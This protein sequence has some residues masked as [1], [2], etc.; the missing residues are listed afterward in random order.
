MFV[1]HIFRVTL[2]FLLLCG[3]LQASE[4]VFTSHNDIVVMEVESASLTGA[5]ANGPWKM[6]TDTAGYTG[7]G[8]YYSNQD[9]IREQTD[10][11]VLKYHFKIDKPGNYKMIMRVH[12]TGE[13]MDQENDCF[14]RLDDG[15]WIKTFCHHRFEWTWYA[16]GPGS[17][18]QIKRGKY[19]GRLVIP[20]DHIEADT[21]HYYSHSFISDDHGKSWK[22]GGR[23]PN[24]QVNE[25]E[26]VE[27]A[28]GR[29]MLNMR[30]YNRENRVRQIA[31]STDGGESWSDQAFDQKLIEPICQASIHR[32]L[33]PEG[34]KAGLIVFSNPASQSDRCCMTVRGS[35]D[36]GLSW[37]F[38]QL[39]YTGPS[40]YSDLAV[41]PNGM[42]G[43]LYERGEKNP[44]ETIV[45]QTVDVAEL[46]HIRNMNGEKKN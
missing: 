20:C 41:L 28:D 31:F 46:D 26:V 42:V 17:G 10:A 35:F 16:T 29:L 33:W 12:Y 21:K 36:D 39:L 19:K 15:T 9:G 24:H 1:R 45:L 6:G 11:T 22:I 2:A 5:L 37:P 14:T 32:V 34:N 44:Y 23:T 13:P 8:Y 38:E 43:C 25:C 18:I 4:K 27:L 3:V 30:N 7:S 40:A